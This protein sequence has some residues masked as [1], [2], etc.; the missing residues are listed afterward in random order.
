MK[1]L[2]LGLFLAVSTVVIVFGA[3]LWGFV[4]ILTR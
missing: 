3:I 2:I 1:E 4:F